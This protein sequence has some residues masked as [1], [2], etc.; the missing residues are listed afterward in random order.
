MERPR[1][2]DAS[3][4]P[5]EAHARLCPSGSQTSGSLP[6]PRLRSAHFQKSG[7]ERVRIGVWFLRPLSPVWGAG[8]ASP[9]AEGRPADGPEKP[10]LGAGQAA[11]GAQ[12]CLVRIRKNGQRCGVRGQAA[13][14]SRGP[15]VEWSDGFPPAGSPRR[16]EGAVGGGPRKEQGLHWAL[17]F[18]IH[19]L[20]GF[21]SEIFHSKPCPSL[22]KPMD[23]EPSEKL[24]VRNGARRLFLFP[25]VRPGPGWETVTRNRSRARRDLPSLP[26][27]VCSGRQSRSSCLVSNSGRG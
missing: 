27:G 2:G 18:F 24:D 9:A 17:V 3:S 1:T 15:R 10:P 13:E 4:H 14:T 20:R 23:L 19:F 5:T 22:E 7:T 21:T 25:L 11:G 16:V 12:S 6:R 8:C 26:L